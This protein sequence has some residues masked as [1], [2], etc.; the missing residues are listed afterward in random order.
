M[1]QGC[2]KRSGAPHCPFQF[3]CSFCL[4]SMRVL[5][6]YKL[7]FVG[8]RVQTFGLSRQSMYLLAARRMLSIGLLATGMIQDAIPTA[9]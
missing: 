2:P 8:Q 6:A 9:R 7:R 3:V 4:A 5:R 1:P